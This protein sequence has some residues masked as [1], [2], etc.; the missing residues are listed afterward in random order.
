[1]LKNITISLRAKIIAAFVV[2]STCL[3]GGLSV[4]NYLHLKEQLF[5][6]MRKK[7]AN[8]SFLGAQMIDKSAFATL[9][10]EIRSGESNRVI[11]EKIQG[12][13]AYRRVY[14]QLNTIRDSYPEMIRYIYTFVKGGDPQSAYFVVDANAL[15]LIKRAS[16]GLRTEEIA[17]FN[18]PWEIRIYPAAQQVMKTNTVT[19]EQDFT[20]DKEMQLHLLSGYAPIV[21]DATH[22]VLGYLALDVSAR[23]A[24]QL[25][26]DSV[27]NSL[28]ITIAIVFLSLL[29]SVYIG[30]FLT[31]TIVSLDRIVNRFAEN[32]FSARVHVSSRDEVG[33]LGY[34]LNQ[35]AGL[36]EESRLRLSALLTAYG[37]FVPQDYIK[38][39]GKS[40]IVELKLGDYSQKQMTVLFTDIRGFTSL[41]EKMS[42]YEN[43][44]FIN[45]FLKRMGPIVRQNGGIIDK[46]IGD[47]IMA[48]FGDQPEA[49][50]TTAVNM[51]EALTS[52]NEHRLSRSY[53]AID[54]G[55]GIHTGNIMVGT[56]GEQER[57]DG[58]VIGDSVNLASRLE[59]L[60]KT[61]GAHIIVSEATFRLL[62]NRA[63]FT[64]R[65]L[66]KVIVKGK[67]EPV[68]IIEVLDGKN[69]A[70]TQFK[71]DQRQKFEMAAHAFHEGA[72]ADALALFQEL[73]QINSGDASVQLY[74][75]RCVARQEGRTVYGVDQEYKKKA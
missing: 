41:S 27:R 46:Y 29:I 2:L 25:L 11:V 73:N 40:D 22:V 23:D 74:L 55:V 51:F 60:T 52:Y 65:F 50:L 61:Y 43:F 19:I 62:P 18:D 37:R 38:L 28:Y 63:R 20:F 54:M 32:D 24:D 3:S 71:R 26:A 59:S 66:D 48:L 5:Q 30:R 64:S 1:M 14:D 45:S 7:L 13:P 35:M 12:S 31:G 69:D 36:I 6:D 47:A 15:T 17:R 56:V 16:M 8:I 67:T 21:D 58:T 33:R 42:P 44:A 10:K 57:M 68:P 34:S 53:E 49:A 72:T 39:L 9:T 70:V 75:E 4:F